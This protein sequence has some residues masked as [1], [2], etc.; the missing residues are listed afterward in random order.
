MI[1]TQMF[2]D[3]LMIKSN[4]KVGFSRSMELACWLQNDENE[5]LCLVG[6]FY[7][8]YTT[9]RVYASVH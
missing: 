4:S 3:L 7:T 8:M 1:I 5:Q 2:L 6:H 9:H